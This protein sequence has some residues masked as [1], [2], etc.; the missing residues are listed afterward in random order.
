MKDH[1]A[2]I[3][4]SDPASDRQKVP[5]LT[6][7]KLDD[8]ANRVQVELFEQEWGTYCCPFWTEQ[9]KMTELKQCLTPELKTTLGPVGMA[10]VFE[11]S[12]L[13]FASIKT[14]LLGH[15]NLVQDILEYL[16]GNQEP[17]EQVL[18]F[19]KRM[20][21]EGLNCAFKIHEDDIT[22]KPGD[23][24]FIYFNDFMIKMKIM[25]GLQDS[26]K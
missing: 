18:T 7:P 8:G 2:S 9:V 25:E 22:R 13:Q 14:F 1:I 17:N 16:K 19:L 6:R 15:Q 23:D 4:K 26:R 5:T 12:E 21:V 3:H 11:N 20:N 10:E 24:G